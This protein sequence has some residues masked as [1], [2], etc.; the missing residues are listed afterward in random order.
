MIGHG[1]ILAEPSQFAIVIVS[2]NLGHE[3]TDGRS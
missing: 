1:M 2:N 3:E